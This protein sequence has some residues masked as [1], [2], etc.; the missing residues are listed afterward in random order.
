MRMRD[1]LS[2]IPVRYKLP[3]TF[4]FLCLVAFGL[5]GYVVTTTARDSLTTQIQLRLNERATSLNLV[6]EKSLE[7][8]GRRVE[9]CHPPKSVHIVERVV[10]DLQSGRRDVAEFWIQ[11]GE[12]FVHIRYFAVRDEEGE[13]LGTLEVTQDIAPLRDLEGE[14]RL[15]AEMPAEGAEA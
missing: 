7:L 15:M 9:D 4:G 8:L 10:D 1:P 14:R 5:G 12:R 2:W 11:M 13:Y 3:L 6:V